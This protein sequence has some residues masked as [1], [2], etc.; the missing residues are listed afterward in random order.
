MQIIITSRLETP[1]QLAEWLKDELPR[2]LNVSDI[3]FTF[4]WVPLPPNGT[5]QMWMDV[6]SFSI[7][8]DEFQFAVQVLTSIFDGTGMEFYTPDLN[9]RWMVG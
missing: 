7:P 2:H 1:H 9:F 4:A 8:E 5:A 3:G 6:V